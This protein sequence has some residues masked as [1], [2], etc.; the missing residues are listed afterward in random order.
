MS[1]F[2][3]L[4]QNVT[5]SS[6]NS[7]T[8]NVNAGVTWRG[9]SA[10]TLRVAGIKVTLK[11]DQNCTVYIDQSP[12]GLNW[13]IVDSFDYWSTTNNFS[14]TVHAVNSYFRV[15]VKNISLVNTQTFRLQSCL[16]PIIEPL[17]R[18]VDA[19]GF[20]KVCVER[21][22]GMFGGQQIISPMGANKVAIPVLL[23]GSPF[24]GTTLDPNYWVSGAT[25]GG[26]FIQSGGS[27]SLNTNTTANGAINLN[28][29]R[30]ARYVASSSNYCRQQVRIPSN[31]TTT[32]TWKGR[33]GAY[34]TDNG[35][36][37]EL[38]QANGTS[39]TI[40]RLVCRKTA[41]DANYVDSG[42]F[43]GNR[44]DVYVLDN[45]IHTYE[46]YWTN[47]SAWFLID[48]IIIHKFTGLTSPLVDTP[49]LKIGAQSINAGNNNANNIINIRVVSISR[50]GGTSIIPTSKYQSGTTAG[51]IL[52]Y[53]AGN[54]QRLIVGAVPTSGS[55]VTLYD[56][57]TTGGTV[58]ASFTF[59][60]PSGGNFSPVSLDFAD[61]Q[62]STGLLLVIATQSANVTVIYD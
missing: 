38:N 7:S 15:R 1:Y 6:G 26:T 4:S 55:V 62:F 28:S 46:I 30:I 3:Q 39:T 22:D 29:V 14:T 11:A 35:Y 19:E 45:N 9:V 48:D 54:L 42:S 51:L 17:P 8:N 43:N 41:S 27:I 60:F 59:L 36:F 40:L 2:S 10:S 25:N 5:I 50:L 37:F 13:D 18:S 12:D 44:G 21:T 58:L 24:I 20:L 33:W 53:G 32:G 56:G 57:L 34:D 61:T 49:S 31:N 16:C 23:A 47:K 52:K